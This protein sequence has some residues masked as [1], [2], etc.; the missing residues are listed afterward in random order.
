MST[1]SLHRTSPRPSPGPDESPSESLQRPQGIAGEIPIDTLITHLVASKRSLSSISVVQNATSILSEA[2]SALESTTV[3]AA[4]TIYLRRSLASQAKILRSVQYEL[5]TSIHNVGQ[6]FRAVLKQ[7]DRT[8]KKLHTTIATLQVTRIEDGFKTGHTAESNPNAAPSGTGKE[9]LHDFVDDQPVEAL[10]EHLKDAIDNVRQS[11]QEMDEAML[12]FQR[13]LQSVNAALSDDAAPLSRIESAA[14]QPDMGNLL[15]ALEDH[16]RE[17]A[18]SLESLVKHFDLC[19]TAIKHTEGGG[20]AVAKNVGTE[21]LPEGVDVEDFEGPAR[22]MSEEER[23]EMMQV[24]ENDAAEVDDV[25]IEIQDRHAE[26]EAQ[27]DQIMLW[28]ERKDGAYD[29][30]MNAIRLL[31]K[32]GLRLPNLIAESSKLANR[33]AEE[34]IK[35]EDGMA[36]MEDLC[37]VYENFLHAYDGLIVEVA[38]RKA[39]KRQMEK[40]ANEAQAKLDK[41]FE[42]DQARRDTFREEQ[43]DYLPSDIWH[44]LASMPPNFAFSRLNEDDGSVPDLPRKTVED[45]L[46]RLKAEA[47]RRLP[48]Q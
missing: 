17:M 15:R 19:V 16:A 18:Q 46:R 22:S 3:L 44:G 28:K 12:A 39:V 36:G 1:P 42:E 35:I 4:R 24:L 48:E 37:E 45:A 6:D 7:L 31:E 23:L 26:M 43:G 20:A 27:L 9:T 32:I 13:D 21:D 47:S 5:E 14:P 11:Q 25:V 10:K 34:K 2:R 29:D 41:L 8:D 30:V 38:R 40:V 33:W